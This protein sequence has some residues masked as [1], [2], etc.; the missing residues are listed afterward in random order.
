VSGDAMASTY[1][2]ELERDEDGW[3]V[4]SVPAVPG[5]HTQGRSIAQAMKRIRETLSL[6]VYAA[7]HAELVPVVHLPASARATVRRAL[8]ARARAERAEEEAAAVL[9]DSIR[10]L[11]RR[12]SLS[13]RDVAALLELSPSRIDQLRH[14]SKNDAPS[15]VW[16]GSRV[17]AA[18]ARNTSAPRRKA[19][20]K[21]AAS[22]RNPARSTR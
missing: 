12:E 20:R 18:A 15:A 11:T 22:K 21:R 2:V 16:S 1:Q 17:P 9:E 10:E 7:E 6:W 13:T 4:A 5:A 3:W 8:S 14:A 19:G